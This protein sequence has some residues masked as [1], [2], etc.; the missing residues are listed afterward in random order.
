M[1]PHLVRGLDYYNGLVFEWITDQLGAQG[2]VSAG[3]RYNNLVE[4]LGG[5][6][7][8]AVGC[9]VGLERLST[10]IQTDHQVK[11]TIF[12]ASIG[13][14]ARLQSLVLLHQLKQSEPDLEHLAIYMECQEVSL[15]NQN[16]RAQQAQADWFFVLG[17]QELADQ[18]VQVK[19]MRGS[20]KIQKTIAWSELSTFIR[21]NV[22]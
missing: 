5:K 10:L 2:T 4:Q 13:A 3:G 9:A 7:T 11:P 20:Q 16:K 1:N 21:T 22:V 6:P 12:W 19:S 15:N 14:E 8:M 17:A 18:T